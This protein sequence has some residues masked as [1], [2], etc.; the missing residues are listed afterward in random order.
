MSSF[1]PAP[2]ARS[3]TPNRA[4]GASL[5]EKSTDKVAKTLKTASGS[6]CD[7]GG[8]RASAEVIKVV[9]KLKAGLVA[10]CGARIQALKSGQEDMW[11]F[12]FDFCDDDKSGRLSFKEVDS[13]VRETMRADLSKYEMRILWKV[14]DVDGS[15][16]VSAKEWFAA[17]YSIELSSWPTLPEAELD[18]VILS[19][20]TAM[21]K[22]HRVSGNW[23]KMFSLMDKGGDGDITFEDLESLVR[24]N[25]LPSLRLKKPDI[26]DR[27]LKGFWKA[28]DSEYEGSVKR[29]VFLTFMRRRMEHHGITFHKKDH[30][31]KAGTWAATKAAMENYKLDAPPQR[32]MEQLLKFKEDLEDAIVKYFRSSGRCAG[33]NK[34]E[35]FWHAIDVN[36]MQKISF[37]ELE[38][39]IFTKLGPATGCYLSVNEPKIPVPTP[40]AFKLC[41]GL[42]HGDFHAIFAFADDDDSRVVGNKEWADALYKIELHSWPDEDLEAI[43]KTVETLNW[44]FNQKYHTAQTW[45]KMFK[46]MDKRSGAEQEDS[47]T[48]MSFHD[49]VYSTSHDCLGATVD[50]VPEG[51]FKMLWKHLDEDMSGTVNMTE[52]MT[53]MRKNMVAFKTRGRTKSTKLPNRLAYKANK[54]GPAATKT[55]WVNGEC[56]R[57]LGKAPAQE[58]GDDVFYMTRKEAAHLSEALGNLTPQKL[59]QEVARIEETDESDVITE[60]ELRPIIRQFLGLGED[61]VDDD[62]ISATWRHIDELGEG[63]VDVEDVIAKSKDL[64]KAVHERPKVKKGPVDHLKTREAWGKGLGGL[65]V[66]TLTSN[67]MDKARAHTAWA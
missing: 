18:K 37:P 35:L 44:Y 59:R 46:I 31:P 61:V 55:D 62:A 65:G 63:E 10:W 15:G 51:D 4:S 9:V 54:N 53:F 14:V 48:F 43:T 8:S 39:Q 64:H 21:D 60:W 41:K 36:G 66:K 32:S 13:G 50:K 47:L 49:F 27:A 12:F 67:G 23:S 19:F 40:S 34:W 6:T 42:T 7:S 52:F 56:K 57:V 22:W 3:S 17:M 5:R 2:R 26:S 45:C 25:C 30:G 33:H 24:G 20:N 38:A 16:L 28:I 1:S 58:E 29:G 11:M